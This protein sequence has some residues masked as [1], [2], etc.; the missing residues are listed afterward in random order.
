MKSLTSSTP[1]LNMSIFVDCRRGLRDSGAA[2]AGQP[3]ATVFTSC[4][5]LAEPYL[6]TIVY[7]SVIAGG[8][9]EHICTV[10]ISVDDWMWLHQ[11]QIVESLCIV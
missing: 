3:G 6:E 2:Y 9:K 1:K 4:M 10:N 7:P 11:V 5:K 8:L